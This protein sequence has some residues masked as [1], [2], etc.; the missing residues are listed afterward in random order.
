M[1]KSMIKEQAEKLIHDFGDAA[2]QNA[3]EA[4]RDAHRRRNSRFGTVLGGG[5]TRGRPVR[6]SVAIGDHAPV[7]GQQIGRCTRNC[8]VTS[9]DLESVREHQA[10][11]QSF[12]SM[13]RIDARRKN[14]S[15]L[16][17]RFSQS[18]ASRRQRLSH[19]M[20]RST[21]QRRGRM[22]KPLA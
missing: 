20:V 1:K 14:D 3:Q 12:R 15:A 10:G 16:R 17:L 9:R 6:A 13:R 5:C 21:T 4:A 19:A 8:I 7:L 22:T 11:L 18:F 2:Y